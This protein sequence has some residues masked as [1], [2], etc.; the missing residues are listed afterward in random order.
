MNRTSK[1]AE[2]RREYVTSAEPISIRK[3]APKYDRSPSSMAR[4]ARLEGWEA[5]RLAFMSTTNDIVAQVDSE[6]LAKRM[7]S[8]NDAFLSAAEESIQVYRQKIADGEIT[9]TPADITKLVMTVRDVLAPR[10]AEES[11][12]AA[13][14]GLHISESGLR[15]LAGLVETAAR[16]RLTTGAVGRAAEPKPVG[17]S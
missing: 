6:Q 3:L 11:P 9:P 15:Q 12:E 4:I 7:V 16:S 17:S 2:A 10:K 1:Y 5:E 13:G 8:L 14:A